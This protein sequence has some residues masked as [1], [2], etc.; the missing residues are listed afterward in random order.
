MH[1]GLPACVCTVRCRRSLGE[2]AVGRTFAPHAWTPPADGPPPAP[3]S[4][5][6]GGREVRQSADQARSPSSGPR[7]PVRRYCKT[8][9]AASTGTG[10]ADDDRSG[11]RRS[12]R[13][14]REPSSRRWSCHILTVFRTNRKISLDW[15][16][17]MT[18]VRPVSGLD[19]CSLSPP[20]PHG[21]GGFFAREHKKKVC[22][23]P[24][25]GSDHACSTALATA[26]RSRHD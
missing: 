21:C 1:T 26:L 14:G 7:E 5:D 9:P 10:P 16:E 13:D 12:E 2:P 11:T 20:H 15:S 3:G 19:S 4:D 25:T 23:R 18:T 6:R 24:L 8:T 22:S 17:N